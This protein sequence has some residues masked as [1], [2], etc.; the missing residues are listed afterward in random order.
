MDRHRRLRGQGEMRFRSRLVGQLV[1]RSPF[2]RS[3]EPL[4]V[5]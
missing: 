3:D 1:T 4:V 2:P 5:R